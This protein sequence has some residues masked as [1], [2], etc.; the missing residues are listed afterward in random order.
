MSKPTHRRSEAPSFRA[1]FAVILGTNEIASAVAV[2]MHRAGWHTVL[3]HD[4]YPPVIR[5]RMAFHDALFGERAEVDGLPG[6]C[7]ETTIE[8]AALLKAGDCVVV[9]RL[10][11]LDLIPL[12]TIHVLIDARM[13][14]GDTVADLRHLASLTVGLGPGF[15]VA[16]NC[17]IAIETLPSKNGTI[18]YSGRTE[19]ADGQPRA[20]GAAGAERFV[21]S[22]T[23]GRWHS[24]LD[25]GAHVFEDF[26][27]GLLDGV[28][29]AAPLDGVVRG[30][31][32]DGSEVPAGVK[33]LE[34]DSRRRPSWTGIDDRGRAIARA[35]M[36]AIAFEH[37][38]LSRSAALVSLV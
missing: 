8:A 33:L 11:L 24:A 27:A 18:L 20:L 4:P 1:A 26:P 29:I 32:R 34:I 30:I 35:T 31:V 2:Y 37:A 17:D 22:G 16:R 10:G 13:H 12:S 38:R 28:A 6:L 23:K 9:T 15:A 25:I 5:R 21:Y 14:K 3:S 19:A 36:H 7:A